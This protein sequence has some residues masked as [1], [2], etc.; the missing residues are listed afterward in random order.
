VS[1]NKHCLLSS[2]HWTLLYSEWLVTFGFVCP[3]RNRQFWPRCFERSDRVV[4]RVLTALFWEFWPRCSRSSH[5]V[6]P[7]VPT[8]FFLVLRDGSV[9]LD[10]CCWA[11]V[12]VVLY[13]TWHVL[14]FTL[15][16]TCSQLKECS[17]RHHF[18]V[19]LLFYLVI[20]FIWKYII[21]RI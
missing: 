18:Y 3:Y 4:L 8:E 5:C 17:W 19:P 2:C 11:F 12:G 13:F 20:C 6:F 15:L 16:D 1:L 21:V 9:G 14:C 7:R 10:E